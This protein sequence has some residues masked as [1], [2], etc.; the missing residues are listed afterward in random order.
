MKGETTPIAFAATVCLFALLAAG[1]AVAVA[2]PPLRAAAADSGTTLA[3]YWRDDG[4][5]LTAAAE[6]ALARAVSPA[7]ASRIAPLGMALVA[8]AGLAALLAWWL[9][10]AF[11]RRTP[12]PVMWT[13]GA[14]VPAVAALAW[15][16]ARLPAAIDRHAA[17]DPSHPELLGRATGQALAPLV[18]AVE[19]AALLLVALLAARS[20]PRRRASP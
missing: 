10:G 4:P 14:F 16:A 18:T 2:V 3:D 6:V 1:S 20:L 13:F 12:H 15:F 19:L 11:R 7:G 8:A 5:A 17:A 9:L